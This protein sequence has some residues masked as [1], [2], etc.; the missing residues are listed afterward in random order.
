ML[1][2]TFIPRL[3][4]GK[5][6]TTPVRA[7]RNCPVKLLRTYPSDVVQFGN[8]HSVQG[9]IDA[10]FSRLKKPETSAEIVGEIDKLHTAEQK[11]AFVQSFCDETGF[12]NLAEVSKR[13][14][15][16]ARE[17]TQKAAEQSG[18]RVL[19]SG[20]NST[21]SVGK[22]CALPGSDIDGW[23]TIIDGNEDDKG[24]FLGKVKELTNPLLLSVTGSRTDDRP[25]VVTK[26]E[27]FGSLKI[28]DDVFKSSKEMQGKTANYQRN[29]DALHTDWTQAGEFNIDLARSI[30][31]DKDKTPMVRAALVCEILKN[32]RHF[33]PRLEEP[34]ISD[35]PLY[36]FS[37]TQQMQK[38]QKTLKDKHLRRLE[39]L[40]KFG[41]MSTDEKFDLV[42]S[43]IR[44]TFKSNRN[45]LYTEA[46]E[47]QHGGLFKSYAHGNM[48]ALFK[49]LL[50]KAHG[51]IG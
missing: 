20:Y 14:E 47:Q 19:Y 37:N 8:S 30:Q 17:V 32:G 33:T 5:N 41:T 51:G 39:E 45:A 29:I 27:F 49:K 31:Y 22:D 26:D 15:D 21:C 3:T 11:T 6:K 12:P 42:K 16:H 48:D 43:I 24:K 40:A 36:Q 35:N 38:H 18:V 13:I 25:D 7:D 10:I 23:F 1:V 46:T 34:I 28:A 9:H 44:L 50:S 2:N 4:L